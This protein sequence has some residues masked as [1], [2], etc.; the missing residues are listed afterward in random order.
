MIIE[1]LT[2]C[3]IQNE[4]LLE[5]CFVELAM[6]NPEHA[7]SFFEVARNY[8]EKR[9]FLEKLHSSN[10]SVCLKEEI[11]EDI[12]NGIIVPMLKNMEEIAVEEL[13][14]DAD[15]VDRNLMNIVA[16]HLQS[17]VPLL[18]EEPLND[19][20]EQR[21]EEVRSLIRVL[22]SGVN[23]KKGYTKSKRTNL[24]VEFENGPT[25][26]RGR[27]KDAFVDALKYMGIEKVQRL[28]ITTCGEPLVSKTL[29]ENLRYAAQQPECEG[30][31]VFTYTSTEKK[32]E[33]LKTIALKLGYRIRAEVIA[34]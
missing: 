26:T 24:R 10:A 29:S 7:A 8:R 2:E 19:S 3:L 18:I 12:L 33:Y 5:K 22:P 6:H 16:R 34:A 27:A 32:V 11:P 28:G 15:G 25:I 31:Y 14:S 20:G 30:Y 1:N 21:A 23:H 4:T 17:P 9:Q 13:E